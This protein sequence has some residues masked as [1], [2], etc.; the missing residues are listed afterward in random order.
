MSKP[1][2]RFRRRLEQHQVGLLALGQL[3][4]AYR[5]VAESQDEKLEKR[6]V[7]RVRVDDENGRHGATFG[8]G[9]G[10]VE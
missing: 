8:S 10:N 4:L 3:A 6:P 2:T 9:R 1:Q 7:R 5:S